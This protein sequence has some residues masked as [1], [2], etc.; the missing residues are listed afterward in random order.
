MATI[1]SLLDHVCAGGVLNIGDLAQVTRTTRRNV[2]R[3]RY[4]G[5]TVRRDVEERLLELR[6]VVDLARQAM[7]DRQARIWLRSP[8]PD[9]DGQ[10]PL[11]L[12][13]EGTA[14]LVIDALTA[15]VEATT[16]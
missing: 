9:L 10:R 12:V 13:S 8:Q 4:R 15:I 16:D 6:A 11:D 1:K 5:A 14:Y 3:W 7:P 2:V